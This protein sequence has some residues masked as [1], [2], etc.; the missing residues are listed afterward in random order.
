[1][2]KEI[3]SN[4]MNI[5]AK[6]RKEKGLTQTELA[7][8]LNIRQTT[9]SSWENNISLP[10][11]PSLIKFAELFEV[12]TDYLLGREDDLGNV[13]IPDVSSVL[14]N[15]ENDLLRFYRAMSDVEKRA[16]FDTAKAFYGNHSK[17]KITI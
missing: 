14:S 10:D 9:I 6:L 8:K 5:F 1:M 13:K 4:K 16:I 12:S 2:T 7:H 17:G 3:I 15:D 11:Y